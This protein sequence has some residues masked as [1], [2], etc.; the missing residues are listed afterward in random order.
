MLSQRVYESLPYLY[1][2]LGMSILCSVKNPY[3]LSSALLFI[4]A[5]AVVWV[6][7]S[8]HRRI[9]H[10][11][12]QQAHGSLPFWC[13]EMLPFSYLTLGVSL[14]VYSENMLMYPSAVVLAVIGFQV[15]VMRALQRRP[16][17][18]VMPKRVSG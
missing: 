8:E 10:R 18:H 11:L 4:L 13:Y 2:G 5:G 6:V 1:L 7:R 15:W 12:T 16:S 17:H 3:A 14:L 9:R